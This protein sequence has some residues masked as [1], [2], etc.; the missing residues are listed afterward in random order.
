VNKLDIN[1]TPSFEAINALDKLIIR[2][3]N[4]KLMR[5]FTMS[6]KDNNSTH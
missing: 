5:V 6:V 2:Q 1:A 3:Q 4:L